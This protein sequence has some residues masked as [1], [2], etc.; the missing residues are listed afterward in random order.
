M[1][2]SRAK[3]LIVKEAYR[4]NLESITEE[5]NGKGDIEEKRLITKDPKKFLKN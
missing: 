3:G 2:I 4:I 1:S 5:T